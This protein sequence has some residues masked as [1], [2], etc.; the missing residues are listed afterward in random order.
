MPQIH[1]GTL[2][3]RGHRVALVVSRFNEL[4]T[5]KLL[6][7]AL[8]CLVRHGA[9]DADLHVVR[10]PGSFEVPL[11]ARKLAESGRYDAVVCLAAILG[12]GAFTAVAGD[13]GITIGG[14]EAR[15]VFP[16]DR[17]RASLVSRRRTWQQNQFR[18]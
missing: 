6:A 12:L 18:E 11:A 7:G 8:D 15:P 17:A 16:P 5:E 2:D 4:F 14:E 13:G 10:V 9:S 3:A 1:E